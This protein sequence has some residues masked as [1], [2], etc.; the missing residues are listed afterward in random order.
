MDTGMAALE[1]EDPEEYCALDVDLPTEPNLDKLKQVRKIT[2]LNCLDPGGM[3]ALREVAP[4]LEELEVRNLRRKHLVEIQGLARLRRLEVRAPDM[5]TDPFLVPPLEHDGGLEFLRVCLSAPTA[6]SL[7]YAH[8]RTLRHV[9]VLSPPRRRRQGS[10]HSIYFE[11]LD[12]HLGGHVS[13]HVRRS[14]Y[15]P[16]CEPGDFPVLRRVEFIE[17]PR[18]PY[19]INPSW[20][21]G[22]D[23]DR[24]ERMLPPGV[25]VELVFK[26]KRLG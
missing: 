16:R 5:W 25:S 26:P 18:S 2:A 11:T 21:V 10:L 3:E 22:K 13:E 8:N 20:I 6:G 7:I 12:Y 1:D 23:M 15:F 4:Y 14:P 19:V 17:E 24:I 9:Q